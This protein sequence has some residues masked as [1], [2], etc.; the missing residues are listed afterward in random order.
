[1]GWGASS[2]SK[3]PI[4]E[5]VNAPLTESPIEE[6]GLDDITP[7]G[8][9]GGRSGRFWEPSAFVLRGAISFEESLPEFSFLLRGE[10]S[11]ALDELLAHS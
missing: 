5:E 11:S 10:P 6:D 4:R 7:I 8:R 9:G 2:P 1:M 3:E